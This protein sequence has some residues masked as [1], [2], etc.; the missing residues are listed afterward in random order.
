MSTIPTV[1][2]LKRYDIKEHFNGSMAPFIRRIRWQQ[3]PKPVGS[4][5]T[6]VVHYSH[7][8]GMTI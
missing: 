5:L 7:D 6:L 4:T 3:A 8:H 1:R 2:Y